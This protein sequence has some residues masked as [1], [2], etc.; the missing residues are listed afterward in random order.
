MEISGESEGCDDEEVDETFAPRLRTRPHVPN[1]R[2][3][4]DLTKDLGLTK[5]VTKSQELSL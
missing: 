2:E 1:Q 3:L 4:D 5:K